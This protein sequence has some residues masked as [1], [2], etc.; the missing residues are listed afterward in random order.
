MKEHD[1][2]IDQALAKF[3]CPYCKKEAK[4]SSGR[5]LHLKVCG[6]YAENVT[7]SKKF[8]P[9]QR[10]RYN[11][12]NAKIVYIKDGLVLLDNDEVVPAKALHE[13]AVEIDEATPTPASHL[14]ESK[15]LAAWV[16]GYVSRGRNRG[17]IEWLFKISGF[18]QHRKWKFEELEPLLDKHFGKPKKS[19]A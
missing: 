15:S 6:G 13:V 3:T 14:K 18:V 16:A 1:N 12:K 10:V 4:S 19:K 5:T 9:T 7:I 11:M 2:K 8:K 17:S